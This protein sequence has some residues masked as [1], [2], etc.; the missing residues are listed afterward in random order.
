MDVSL[1]FVGEGPRTV[2]VPADATVGDLVAPLSVSVHEVSVVADG[3]TLP[4]DAPV[5]ADAAEIRVVRLIKGG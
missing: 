3:R 5:P 4:A 2:E 1:E